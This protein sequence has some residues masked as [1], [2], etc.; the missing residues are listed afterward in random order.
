MNAEDGDTLVVT[1]ETV[2]LQ[3]RWF[4]QPAYGRHFHLTGLTLCKIGVQKPVCTRD[5]IADIG[6]RHAA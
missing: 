1:A 4:A 2:A 3:M 6:R 5:S